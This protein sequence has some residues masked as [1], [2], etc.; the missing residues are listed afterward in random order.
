MRSDSLATAE[1]GPAART[2]AK[3]SYSI[4]GL[5]TIVSQRYVSASWTAIAIL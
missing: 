3:C 4:V 1:A 5:D 2:E